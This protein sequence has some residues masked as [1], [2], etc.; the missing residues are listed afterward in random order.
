MFDMQVTAPTGKFVVM[1]TS[2]GSIKI[3]LFADKAPE[4]VKNFLQYV[5]DKHYDGLVFHRVI[6]DFM[7]QGGGMEPGLKQRATRA[8]IKNESSNGLNNERGTLAMARTS[9]PDSATSQFFINVKDN[10]FL[11]KARSADNVGYCVFG[12]VV[13]GMDIVDKIR[14]VQTGNVGGHSDVPTTDVVIKTARVK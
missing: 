3:E 7:I 5:N 10:G 9:V 13:D 4:T 8:P 11:D 14:M 2:L 1:D 6:K 12:K